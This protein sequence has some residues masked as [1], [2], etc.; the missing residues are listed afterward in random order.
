M[1]IAQG[2]SI[3]GVWMVYDSV[4]PFNFLYISVNRRRTRGEKR[5]RE[6]L[7]K[8][9]QLRDKQ[10]DQYTYTQAIEREIEWKIEWV[11]ERRKGNW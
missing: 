2:S 7:S 3:D 9:K 8:G 5:E 11:Q 6:Q 1:F 10:R 4:H